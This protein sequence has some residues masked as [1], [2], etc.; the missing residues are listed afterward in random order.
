MFNSIFQEQ[1]LGYRLPKVVVYSLVQRLEIALR[2]QPKELRK[3]LSLHVDSYRFATVNTIMRLAGFLDKP[4]AEIL[5][6][7][8][9]PRKYETTEFIELAGPTQYD[10]DATP[11]TVRRVVPGL[12][13]A[14]QGFRELVVQP[15]FSHTPNLPIMATLK[16][17]INGHNASLTLAIKD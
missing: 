16:E 15:M 1:Q 12:I 6:A 3:L 13:P 11:F 4:M 8:E 2:H 9:I 10:K 5:D 17:L 14:P 7:L